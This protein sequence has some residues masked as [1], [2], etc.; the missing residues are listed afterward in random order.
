MCRHTTMDNRQEMGFGDNPQVSNPS[1]ARGN[2]DGI[3]QNQ[4]FM[5]EPFDIGVIRLRRKARWLLD[6]RLQKYI[7]R[8]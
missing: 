5:H 1:I 8:T 6:T 3:A 7:Q 4:E 2:K